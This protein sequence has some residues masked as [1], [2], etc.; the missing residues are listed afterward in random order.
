MAHGQWVTL[1]PDN[2]PA[3]MSLR[4]KLPEGNPTDEI[5]TITMLPER[6]KVIAANMAIISNYLIDL[7][8]KLAA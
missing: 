7:R 1:V 4:E 2:V 6:L 8:K 3:V 5:V